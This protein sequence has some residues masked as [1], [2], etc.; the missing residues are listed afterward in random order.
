VATVWRKAIV[1]KACKHDRRTDRQ[2]DRIAIVYTRN[3]TIVQ[4]L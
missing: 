4:M 2:T 1:D 3:C